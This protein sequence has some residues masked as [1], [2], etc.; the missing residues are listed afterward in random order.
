MASLVAEVARGADRAASSS[1]D[2]AAGGG[3]RDRDAAR[4]GTRSDRDRRP[5][6][7]PAD[8]ERQRGRAKLLAR[9][10]EEVLR[11]YAAGA[12]ER[13]V[14][15]LRRLEVGALA[16]AAKDHAD[17]L[18]AL[19]EGQN[20]VAERL[21]EREPDSLVP[22]L[23][24]HLEVHDLHLE[25]RDLRL[26]SHTRDRVSAVAELYA[27]T[28]RSETAARLASDALTAI[29]SYLQ[30]A[31]ALTSGRKL[32]ARAVELD[33]RN[34][35]ARLCIA[36]GHES[37][38]EYPEALRA[39]DELAKYGGADD[40]VR[41]RRATT[42]GRLGRVDEAVALYESLVA[43]SAQTWVVTLAYQELAR[44]H[45]ARDRPAAAV[46]A[47]ERGARRFP[48]DPTILLQLSFALERRG[49]SDRALRILER[50]DRVRV[51][52]GPES[53]ARTRY[54][55]GL[56]LVG[57][58]SELLD[59]SGLALLPMLAG[60]LDSFHGGGGVGRS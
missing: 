54:Q 18:A 5:P 60:T 37:H 32:L 46:V 40:E 28:G 24:L 25:N 49:A 21:A 20:T 12:G 16:D 50:V 30:G 3:R 19:R 34:L 29:G 45:L 44:I 11:S 56:D 47:L 26:A 35:E 13:A 38:G 58:R 14:A 6:P 17:L 8:V 53:P 41:L 55:R 57:G 39:L 10:Y 4:E 23:L 1:P 43:G 52:T 51:D 31:N 9:A 15:D 27:R 42:L 48:R 36:L 22:L 7:S 33:P 59:R 2:A